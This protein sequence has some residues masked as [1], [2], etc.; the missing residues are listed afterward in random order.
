MEPKKPEHF[1]Q[2]TPHDQYKAV[3]GAMDGWL[4]NAASG[5]S[6]QIKAV[7]ALRVLAGHL[8][9]LEPF[10]KKGSW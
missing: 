9:E 10:L 4:L 6:S 5:A 7:N 1:K 2:E 3:V 8:R